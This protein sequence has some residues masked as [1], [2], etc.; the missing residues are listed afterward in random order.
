MCSNTGAITKDECASE[1][2]KYQRHHDM[3]Y[4]ASEEEKKGKKD[5]YSVSVCSEWRS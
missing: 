4:A 2:T 3:T 1:Y 5:T